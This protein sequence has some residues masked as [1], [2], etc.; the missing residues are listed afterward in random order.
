MNGTACIRLALLTGSRLAF[1]G[2]DRMNQIDEAALSH[3]L[4]DEDEV[5]SM[6]L[7]AP[8]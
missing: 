4:F 6:R 3:P 5:I 1:L 7:A 8:N 2:Q